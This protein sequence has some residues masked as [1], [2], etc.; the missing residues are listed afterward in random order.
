MSTL[1][2][3]TFPPM[4]SSTSTGTVEVIDEIA[5][6][7]RE[8]CRESAYDQPFFRPEWIA[9]Y[10]KAFERSACLKLFT[11]HVGSKLRAVLPL[12]RGVQWIAGIPVRV[13]RSPS[14]MYSCRFELV[15]GQ[16]DSEESIACIW[17]QLKRESW[18]VLRFNFVPEG[19]GIQQL[20]NMAA[21]EGFPT[22]KAWKFET[23][24]IAMDSVVDPLNV[25]PKRH[26]RQNLRRRKRKAAESRSLALE[27]FSIATPELLHEFYRL[28]ASG[29]KGRR[30]TAILYSPSA[31]LFYDTLAQVAG[32]YGYLSLYFL[33]FDNVR[34]AGHLG[35]F[36]NGRYHTPKI[37]YDERYASYGPGHL[38]IEAALRDCITRGVR[39]FDFYGSS[40]P[41]KMEWA[42]K[43]RP[44]HDYYVFRNNAFGRALHFARFRIM[45]RLAAMLRHRGLEHLRQT[46]LRRTK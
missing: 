41:W 29:W 44:H 42:T 43:A 40:M 8:L 30:R 24:Y 28:E 39:E 45:A 25:C 4:R 37:G 11:A 5:E 26:F 35:L 16:E 23:P 1:R 36:Y 15:H 12:L 33:L 46:I 34:V 10:L 22:A 13:L 2:V 20:Y 17:Q 19:G 21:A 9:A 3:P 32:K 7:W 14:N 27:H 18:D 31:R 38:I 6:S